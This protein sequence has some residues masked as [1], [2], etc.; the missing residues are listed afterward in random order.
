MRFGWHITI[1]AL[2]MLLCASAQTTPPE[3]VETGKVSPYPPLKVSGSV[4]PPR[5]IYSPDPEYSGKAQKARYQGTCVLWLIVGTDGRPRDIRVARSI[6]MGLDEKAIEAVRNWRFKPARKDGQPV[7]VQINVEVEFRLFGGGDSEIRRLWKK[8]DAGDAKAQLKL[9]QILLK[10]P[11]TAKEDEQGLSLLQKAA[12][13][14]LPEA[15]FQM[16]EY[17]YHH[18]KDSPDY[19]TAYMWY[20]LARRGGYKRSEKVL[21]VLAPRLPPDQL[22]EAQK[23]VESWTSD[24][25]R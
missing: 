18:G 5:V 23:R 22:A 21:K 13:Q 24:H 12:R 6:G 8:A 10:P 9:A 20:A 1:L 2:T 15:Q 4:T 25:D 11:T 17:I 14:G 7:S 16:G 3:S 19:V